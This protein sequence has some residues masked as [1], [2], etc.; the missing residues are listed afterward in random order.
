MKVS[1]ILPCLAAVILSTAA[2]QQAAEETGRTMPAGVEVRVSKVLTD[3]FFT[4]V[5]HSFAYSEV[6]SQMLL[7]LDYTLKAG[8][9]HPKIGCLQVTKTGVVLS[10]IKT[11]QYRSPEAQVAAW[12]ATNGDLPIL[13]GWERR[14]TVFFSMGSVDASITAAVLCQ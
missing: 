9:T 13:S 6:Q 14:G 3:N 1:P 8:A 12:V 2:C 5:E 11:S 4:S 7:Y 10:G